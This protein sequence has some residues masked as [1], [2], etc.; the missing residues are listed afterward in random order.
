M[1]WEMNDDSGMS[2]GEE[3]LLEQEVEWLLWRAEQFRRIE[4]KIWTQ[5]DGTHIKVQDM[6]ERHINN[7]I[8]M[9]KRDK[10]ESINCHR[11]IKDA[12]IVVF[13]DELKRRKKQIEDFYWVEIE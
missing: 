3:Y 11:D 5:R 8:R 6:T 2:L 9:L 1:K 7:C 12:W 4:N 10:N 13:E